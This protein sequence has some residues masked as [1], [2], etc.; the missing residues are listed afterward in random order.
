MKLQKCLIVMGAAMA[1]FSIAATGQNC[2]EIN[3]PVLK[4][5]D[6]PLLDSELVP[7]VMTMIKLTHLQHG[8]GSEKKGL[9]MFGDQKVTIKQMLAL[10][11][12]SE[13][14][15]Q[16]LNQV[17]SMIQEILK[18]YGAKLSKYKSGIAYVVKQWA[19][20]RNMD[21]AILLVWCNISDDIFFSQRLNSF[22]A[23][24]QFIDEFILFINDIKCTCTKSSKT[25][26]KILA[27][28]KAGAKKEL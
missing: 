4:L 20:Q 25:Y 13:H 26:D 21:N 7:I 23:V 3:H 14:A 28:I 19:S 17:L 22:P 1:F 11:Q 12:N 10:D 9:L 8:S 27:T 5:V 6:G 24:D 2:I 16:A 15:R 18:K